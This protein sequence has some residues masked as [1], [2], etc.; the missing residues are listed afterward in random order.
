ML[1]KISEEVTDEQLEKIKFLLFYLRKSRLENA[2]SI[3]CFCEFT[4]FYYT[5]YS[6]IVFIYKKYCPSLQTFLE[7]MVEM[8][9][10]EKLGEKNLDELERILLICSKQL[11][12]WVVKYKTLFL[13]RRPEQISI[14]EECK[15][16]CTQL[17]ASRT[18]A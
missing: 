5:I 7:I 15:S 6:I 12:D 8:E 4:V 3:Q 18:T 13:T 11:C 1:Y 10:K 17:F 9:K 16:H 2:V 14:P